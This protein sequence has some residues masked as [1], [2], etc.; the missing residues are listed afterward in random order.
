MKLDRWNFLCWRISVEID[1]F[2]KNWI[3][4]IFSGKN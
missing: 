4:H 3:V 2:D 1:S